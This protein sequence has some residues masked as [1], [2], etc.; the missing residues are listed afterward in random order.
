M[1]RAKL[2]WILSL[3]VSTCLPAIH[4]ASA[5]TM[6]EQQK[7]P[8]PQSTEAPRTAAPIVPYEERLFTIRALGN[9]CVDVGGQQWW[10]AQAPVFIYLCNGSI[11]QQIRVVE[12]DG[13]HDVSLRTANSSFCIGVK[14][15]PG[16]KIEVGYVLQLQTCNN[17]PAQRFALDGDSIMVGKQDAGQRVS[18]EFVLETLNRSTLDRTPL[19]TGE[20]DASDAQ[21][22]RFYAVDGSNARPHSGFFNATYDGDLDWALTRGWGTVVEVARSFPLIRGAKT[23]AEGVTLRGY[24]K[25]TDNG[26]ELEYP[27]HAFAICDDELKNRCAFILQNN[28]RVT[29]LRLR[30]PKTFPGGIAAEAIFI[31]ENVR[32]TSVSV[33]HVDMSD[34]TGSAIHFEGAFSDYSLDCCSYNSACRDW[35]PQTPEPPKNIYP[36]PTPVKFLSNIIH[37]N[38]GYG[39]VMAAGANPLIRGNLFFWNVHSIAADGHG[40]NG[41]VAHDNLITRWVIPG[42]NWGSYQTFDVHGTEHPGHWYGGKSGD[43][44]D[45]GWNTFLVKD[46]INFKQRGTPCQNTRFHENMLVQGEEAIETQSEPPSTLIKY[47]NKFHSQD[48]L[49]KLAVGDFDGDGLSDIFLGTATTWWY[50]SGG[51][52]EWRFLNRMPEMAD[53]LRFGDFD[54]DRRT[55]VLSVAN[56]QMRVSWAGVSPWTPVAST[57]Q[58]IDD[59]AVGNFDGDN[60][61]DVFVADGVNWRFASA[62]TEFKPIAASN[63]RPKDLR[64]GDFNNDRKTDIFFVAGGSWRLVKG[65]GNG[66]GEVLRSAL[67]PN[68]QGLVIADFDG[69][70]FV[71]VAHDAS[72]KWMYSARGL[73]GF[74]T[75]RPAPS[76]QKIADR[77]VGNFNNDKK[78]DVIIWDSVWFAIAPGGGNPVAKISW[79]G[80]R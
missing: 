11:A 60:R 76:G 63:L 48:P 52:A 65:G 41:Y 5:A 47:S 70:T 15:P 54:G 36:R 10:A 18:R 66:V 38:S 14:T 32:Y 20:R 25:F 53:V 6:P 40:A 28:A 75:L 51:T 61:D 78:A 35:N 37:N 42:Q 29:G 24:R 74:I 46:H 22:F 3:V 68:V 12:I 57:S 44:F 72:G 19:A 80:M 58:T 67:T 73:G 1:K 13:S 69:D 55:D 56:G 23:V 27:P 17:T 26:P 34:W 7:K 2:I 45:I 49:A 50:S 59:M 43:I 79:Q 30:G 31:R 39:I 77:Y 9:R 4:I 16:S 62:A 33:D 8:A 64:F 71:D 21:Y